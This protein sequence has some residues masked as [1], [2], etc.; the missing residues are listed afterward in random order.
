MQF[1]H[2]L[3]LRHTVEMAGNFTTQPGRYGVTGTKAVCPDEDLRRPVFAQPT[4]EDGGGDTLVEIAIP[5]EEALGQNRSDG[6][7]RAQAALDQADAIPDT[8]HVPSATRPRFDSTSCCLHH[9]LAACQLPSSSRPVTNP[10]YS[11][12]R[13]PIPMK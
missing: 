4:P 13:R 8:D 5:H 2:I 12:L 11:F 3:P 6:A 9:W 10:G 1:L 7:A